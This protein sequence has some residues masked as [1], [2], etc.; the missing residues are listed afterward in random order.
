MFNNDVQNATTNWESFHSLLKG[1]PAQDS[2]NHHMF[3]SIG[4]WFYRYLAGI[5]LNGFVDDLIIHPRLTTLLTNVDAEVHT[6]YGPILVSW[7]QSVEEK[8]VIYHVTIP[9]SL[10]SIITFEPVHPTARCISIEE[11]DVLIWDR[12][13]S[14][15]KTDV[16]GIVW[17]R[18]DSIIDGAINVRTEGG[19][20]RWKVRWD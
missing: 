12:S 8:S 14:L 9:N 20:Y 13:S 5:Q 6:V 7:E 11:S 10:H 18:P 17:L 15:L 19:S 3:N 1:Q 16:S 2:L 4:A